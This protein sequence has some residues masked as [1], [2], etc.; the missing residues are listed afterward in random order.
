MKDNK[1]H[2][3]CNLGMSIN[4]NTLNYNITKKQDV[5][6]YSEFNMSLCIQVNFPSSV[7]RTGGF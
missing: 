6:F 4:T 5:L 7:L 3:Y 1:T 2:I